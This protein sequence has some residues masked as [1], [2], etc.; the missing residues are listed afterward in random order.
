M[1]KPQPIICLPTDK[2]SVVELNSS[3]LIWKDV[4]GYEGTY[5]VSDTGLIMSYARLVQECWQRNMV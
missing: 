1:T 5:K 4:V 3:N 2:A